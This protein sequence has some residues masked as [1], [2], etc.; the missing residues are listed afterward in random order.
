MPCIGCSAQDLHG[1]GVAVSTVWEALFLQILCA[2][3]TDTLTLCTK[4]IDCHVLLQHFGT[5]IDSNTRLS[6][7]TKHASQHAACC[8][9]AIT[10]A[11]THL[12]R[13]KGLLPMTS[14]AALALRSAMAV[15]N[16]LWASYSRVPSACTAGSTSTD[17]RYAGQGDL[18][19]HRFLLVGR[20]PSVWC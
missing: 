9:A 5:T 3:C 18:F 20:T 11:H 8:D 17:N 13:K 15:P 14:V 16:R 1:A 7:R 12:S 6:T 19:L 2:L 10:A 4:S